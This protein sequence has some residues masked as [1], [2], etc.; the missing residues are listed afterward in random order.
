M[1][2]AITAGDTTT[3]SEETDTMQTVA[4]GASGTTGEASD[5][6]ADACL[7]LCAPDVG[8][9]ALACDVWSQDCGEGQ[10]C[11]PAIS[12]GGLGWDSL[13]CDDVVPSPKA[14]GETCNILTSE[15]NVV[16]QVD[17]C[18]ATSFCFYTNEQNVGMCTAFCTG[19]EA[20]PVCEGGDICTIANNGVLAL[21]LAGCDPLA[22]DCGDGQGC[23]AIP[24]SGGFAC[25]LDVS[26]GMGTYA[27]DCGQAINGCAPGYQCVPGPFVPD[28]DSNA[29]TCCTEFCD[30]TTPS[31]M[32]EGQ[33]CEALFNNCNPGDTGCTAP[34]GFENVGL[35]LLP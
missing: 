5:D 14:V 2:P 8:A 3:G 31:C 26:F 7:F 20:A 23:Y 35:C 28:C 16:E 12:D 25:A 21:C 29:A 33:G 4:M 1:P 11:H 9:G 27:A 32:G 34:P 6:T 17:D 30:V 15:Y 13:R 18:D 10:K 22:Q 19:S 24:A